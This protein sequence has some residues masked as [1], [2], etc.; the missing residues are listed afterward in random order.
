MGS[1]DYKL[2]YIAAIDSRIAQH[3]LWI[4]IWSCTGTGSCPA[5][6][7]AISFLPLFYSLC[8]IT[9]GPG[10]CNDQLQTSSF[11]HTIH[12]S[13]P[14]LTL[15]FCEKTE[16]GSPQRGR[17]VIIVHIKPGKGKLLS[18][19]GHKNNMPTHVVHFFSASFSKVAFCAAPWNSGAF[20]PVCNIQNDGIS[21]LIEATLETPIELNVLN[22]GSL[23][24]IL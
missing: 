4:L 9:S 6:P 16:T 22:V 17:G 24:Q 10:L 14:W 19:F 13:I 7:S 2:W 20:A 15:V 21:H 12:T 5:S 11:T 1:H 18:L 3:R 8:Y 23:L